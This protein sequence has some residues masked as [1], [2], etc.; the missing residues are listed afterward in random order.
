MNTKNTKV[1]PKFILALVVSL[2]AVST[3]AV[4]NTEGLKIAT[5]DMQKAIQTVDAG[6]KARGQLEKEFNQKK[7]ELQ[8][9]ETLIKKMGEEFKKQSLVLNEEA[10]MKKQGELQEKIM[11]FQEKTSKSQAEIQQ[12]EQQ[13]TEPIVKK[14]R[15]IISDTAKK[16]SY[17]LVLEKNENTVLFSLEKDDLTGEVIELFNKT[18]M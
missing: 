1:T 13:L 14:L 17:S 6:K 3:S 9:E 18:K 2:G 10:R 5:V 16:K 7:K 15:E 8:D 11:K 4:A 12:K